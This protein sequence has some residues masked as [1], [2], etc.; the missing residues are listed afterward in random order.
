MTF[1]E[2]MS[3]PLSI[4]YSSEVVHYEAK[5]ELGVGGT[6]R[7]ADHQ[8]RG[9][10]EVAYPYTV[11]AG[12]AD[13][14]GISIGA[15]KLTGQLIKDVVGRFGYGIND[16]YMSYHAVADDSGH[17]VPADIGGLR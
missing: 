3:L 17:K 15:N 8:T 9:R 13:D 6:G 16:S 4:S 7:A 14:N 5:L 12:D 11:R 1:G 2:N 10:S